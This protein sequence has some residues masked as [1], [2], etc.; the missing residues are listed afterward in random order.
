MAVMVPVMVPMPVMLDHTVSTVL[1]RMH[2]HVMH[3]RRSHMHHHGRRRCHG[4][5]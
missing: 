2:H 3:N 4:G 5:H 1:D